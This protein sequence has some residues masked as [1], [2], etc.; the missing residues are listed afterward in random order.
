[1]LSRFLFAP[2]TF[3]VLLVLAVTGE[4]MLLAAGAAL[5]LLASAAWSLSS[6]WSLWDARRRAARIR[7]Q[8]D[9]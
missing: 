3:C 6:R 2:I 9:R 8:A 4:W 1:M 5:G 7:V